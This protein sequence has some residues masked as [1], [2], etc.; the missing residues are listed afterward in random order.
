MQ[1][2]SWTGLEMHRHSTLRM[3]Y[4][5]V[6]QYDLWACLDAVRHTDLGILVLHDISKV[7]S[8]SDSFSSFVIV[9]GI[10]IMTETAVTFLMLLRQGKNILARLSP[11]LMA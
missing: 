1:N 6:I 2:F 5:L 11:E 7:A 8:M 10:S 9:S 3:H 4:K